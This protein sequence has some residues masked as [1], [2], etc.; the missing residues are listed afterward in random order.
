LTNGKYFAQVIDYILDFLAFDGS[1]IYYL[2]H[3]SKTLGKRTALEICILPF[4]LN[5][6]EEEIAE[7]CYSMY[8]AGVVYLRLLY[9]FNTE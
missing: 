6:I 1:T 9:S 2:G 3:A 8:D 4:L 5:Y 7:L